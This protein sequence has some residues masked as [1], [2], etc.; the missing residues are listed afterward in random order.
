MDEWCDDFNVKVGDTVPVTNQGPP[1]L[2]GITTIDTSWNVPNWASNPICREPWLTDPK[3]RFAP[4][5]QIIVESL[6]TSIPEEEPLATSIPEKKPL[7]T[8]IP[9]DT[10]Y[11]C[12]KMHSA[13]GFKQELNFS[14]ASIDSYTDPV[15]YL[16]I[17][18][19][20]KYV[21]LGG[22]IS[23]ENIDSFCEYIYNSDSDFKNRKTTRRIY[24]NVDGRNFERYL[25]M[26]ERT[27]Y[28]RLVGLCA[29][30]ARCN[31]EKVVM[32]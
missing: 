27:D 28:L 12:C 15:D 7:V 29:D 25:V 13:D 1:E 8:S 11:H 4:S 6:S 24:I 2:P 3:V 20:F 21:T 32:V 31:P 17:L 9:T 19:I 30:W 18:D 16:D 5:E 14:L 10:K 23:D 22:R 26:Y